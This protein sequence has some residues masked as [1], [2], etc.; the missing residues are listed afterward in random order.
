MWKLHWQAPRRAASAAR[1]CGARPLSLLM[2][3]GLVG[4]PLVGEPAWAQAAVPSTTQ[5]GALPAPD[6]EAPAEPAAASAAEP[7]RFGAGRRTRSRPVWEAGLGATALTLPDYRGSDTSRSYLLPLPYLVYRGPW[8]S[9]D[10]G[11]LK[12]ELLDR[13]RLELDFSVNLSVPVRSDGNSARAGMPSLRPALEVGPQLLA[14]LWQ[15]SGGKAKLQLQLPLRF[16]FALSSSTR[17]AGFIFHPRLGLDVRDFAG[18]PG[19]NAG[20]VVGPMFATAR[21]HEYFYTVDPQYATAA[22][23]AYE[24]SGGYSGMQLTLALSKR[25]PNYWFGGFVRADWLE[26][27]AFDDSPL[28]RRK[29]SVA[30]GIAFSYIFAVSADRVTRR[31]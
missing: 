30:A 15:S 6:A 14:D 17:D 4:L 3:L 28:V 19:L 27:A 7:E 11:G 26:G 9:V 1:A 23:P 8:F 12:A 31:E 25:F 21:Q 10:R 5:P 20:L 2:A 29:A 13:G 22:R 16:A 18:Y 24:A